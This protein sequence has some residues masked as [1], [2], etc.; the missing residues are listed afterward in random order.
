[1]LALPDPKRQFVVQTDAS[2]FA[3]GGVI[4]QD[5]G[6]GLQPIAYESRKLRGAE[7]NYS[8]YDKE[9]LGIVHCCKTWWH[10][11]AG[12]PFLVLTDH[13]TL[14]H[15]MTQPSL[16]R[17]QLR[18]LEEL[19]DLS[20]KVEY[21]KGKTNVVA[22]ALSRIPGGPDAV[23]VA[24]L[25]TVTQANMSQDFVDRLKAAAKRDPEYQRL[26]KDPRDTYK[27]IGSLLFKSVEGQLRLVVP[28]TK[29]LKTQLL[30]E[31]HDIPV[32]G[33]LGCDKTYYSLTRWFYWPGM[34][35]DATQYVVCCQGQV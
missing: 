5:F 21:I 33:H 22:D 15:I 35:T 17:R 27:V 30:R 18:Y 14:K 24:E 25:C 19:R 10:Y 34:Y 16:S 32:A 8:T 13:Q 9:M 29:D 31:C 1:M 20:F 28:N 11:L 4:M 2:D 12:A 3:L 23:T 26:V 7:L 6:S